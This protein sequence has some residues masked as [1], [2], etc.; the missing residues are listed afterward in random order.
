MTA[1]L[2]SF[3]RTFTS[4]ASLSLLVAPPPVLAKPAA[5]PQMPSAPVSSL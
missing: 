5:A 1:P 2:K 3:A 4:L